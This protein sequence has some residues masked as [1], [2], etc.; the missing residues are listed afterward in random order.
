MHWDYAVILFLLAVVVPWRSRIRV[1]ELLQSRS[2]D[3]RQRLALYASTAAF[4]WA[5][6]LFIIWRGSIHGLGFAGL[7]LVIYRPLRAMVVAVAISAVLALNQV[8][9]MLRLAR[10]PDKRRGIIGQLAERMLP[11]NEFESWMA[12]ALVLTVAICEEFIYRGFIQYI[13]TNMTKYLVAGAVISAVFF[14]FAHMYQGWRGTITT[15]IA[16]TIFSG[17]RIWTES[18]LPSTIIHFAVDFSAGLAA[19]RLM[20]P[21]KSQ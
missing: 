3:S 16:G 11:R 14:S 17:V 12:L 8:L 9:G 4:Q 6:S 5:I 18:L 20:L 2:I 15:F 1:R 10:L 7:G 19:K 21:G 13:F